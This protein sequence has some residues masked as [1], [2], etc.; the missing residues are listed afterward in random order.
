MLPG[1]LRRNLQHFHPDDIKTFSFKSPDDFADQPALH[2]VWLEQYESGFHDD[3]LKKLKLGTRTSRLRGELPGLSRFF[4]PRLGEMEL[5][6]FPVQRYPSTP[7]ETACARA[8]AF[9]GALISL[10]AVASLLH[11]NPRVPLCAV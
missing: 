1:Q 5:F 9:Q 8:I 10:A 4:A 11:L 7:R 3:F 6:D 2:T